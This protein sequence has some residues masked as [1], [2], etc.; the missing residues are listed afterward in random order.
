VIIGNGGA[1]YGVRGYITAYDA[2]SGDQ[3]W[4]WFTVPGDP[5]K[6]FED[7]S[8]AKAAKTWDPAGKYWEAGGGG[9]AWDTL[10][11]D[12]SQ[13]VYI[14]TGNGSPWARHPQPGR[15]RQSLSRILVALNADTGN[16]SGTIRKPPAITGTIPRRSR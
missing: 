9:T 8:M 7:E 3:K 11:F 2:T 4:R 5:S 10:T 13:P 14:G 6:P 12:P 16:T 15:R 1:E